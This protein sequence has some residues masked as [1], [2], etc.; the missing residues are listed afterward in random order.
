MLAVSTSIVMAGTIDFSV[1]LPGLNRHITVVDYKVKETDTNGSYVKLNKAAT[2]N[3]KVAV[4]TDLR[5]KNSGATVQYSPT[6]DIST[7][8]GKNNWLGA[9]VEFS[10]KKGD[11]IR[12]RMHSYTWNG[13]DVVGT[14]DYK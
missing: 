2:G 6:I 8:D 7:R 14:W 5:F 11:S 1:R 10:G 13:D 9:F 4:W 12:L 3:D